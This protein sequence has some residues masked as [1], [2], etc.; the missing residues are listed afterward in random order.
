MYD[1]ILQDE[2]EGRLKTK[3]STKGNMVKGA[4][5]RRGSSVRAYA[6][7]SAPS[8]HGNRSNGH[9]WKISHQ[10]GALGRALWYGQ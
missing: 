10:G 1:E 5:S 3:H 4:S 7:E 9:L 6:D 2:R 8:H